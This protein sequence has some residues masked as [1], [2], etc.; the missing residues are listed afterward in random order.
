MIVYVA[1]LNIG[2]AGLYL[3]LGAWLNPALSVALGQL[4]SLLPWRKIA[5]KDLQ[6]AGWMFFLGCAFHHAETAVHALSGNWSASE[7]A[8]T[9]HVVPMTL[10]VFGAG[11][12][13]ATAATLLRGRIVPWRADAIKQQVPEASLGVGGVQRLALAHS[14]LVVITKAH[15]RNIDEVA[16]ARARVR[17][18][19]KLDV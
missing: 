6:L 14:N 10:Q 2:L 13:I 7:M 18:Q 3:A 9:L 17:E 15:E 8:S 12:Y 16:A 4:T 5:V 11:W 1:L 19:L